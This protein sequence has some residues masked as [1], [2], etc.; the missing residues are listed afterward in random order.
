MGLPDAE[1]VDYHVHHDTLSHDGFYA[2]D[3]RPTPGEIMKELSTPKYTGRKSGTPGGTAAALY[4]AGLLAS[5]GL[6]PFGDSA[7]SYLHTFKVTPI[8][9]NGPMAMSVT[10][11]SGGAKIPFTYRKHWRPGR[12]TA[13]ADLSAPLIFLGYG[14]NETKHDDYKGMDVTGAVVV[15]LRGCPPAINDEK[16][17]ND[18]AKLDKA[19][20]NKA[21]AFILLADDGSV[22]IWGGSQGHNLYRLPVAVMKRG[23]AESFL[24]P[25]ST[26]ASVQ[27][28]LDTVGPQSFK[29]G[30]TLK[31]L[32]S[33]KV[34]K[35]ALAHNVVARLRSAPAGTKS[36][37]VS[38][39]HYD[40]LGFDLPPFMYFPG[41]L[42]NASGTAVVIDAACRLA[43]DPKLKLKRNLVFALWAAE[44]DGLIGSRMWLDAAKLK[45]SEI[46]Y[47]FNLDMVG[48]T[49]P[50]PVIV[51]ISQPDR[52]TL[53]SP[54]KK[55][56]KDLKLL[57]QIGTINSGSSDHA[58]FV[59]RN[60]SAVYLR[61][62]FPA[63]LHYHTAADLPAQMS[64][65]KL[66]EL[67]AFLAAAMKVLA[68]R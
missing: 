52:T 62:P 22:N 61:G 20:A 31:L 50:D 1:A 23:P 13:G 27:S 53:E 66:D 35:D 49:G 34:T 25:G 16:V 40:H 9:H 47:S 60:I 63:P 32:M 17:C 42:D 55:L 15:A 54:L 44:E 45:P 36:H 67:G 43:A 39:A 29:T 19:K 68:N 5:C 64:A 11:T 4:I 12:L 6:E 18:I 33:R 3:R 8:V 30:L 14:L 48:G 28:K 24:P 38:G 37:I 65:S 57:A 56:A 46:A 10:P 2:P 59:Q 7:L 58:N 21:K 26:M 51:D 41:S